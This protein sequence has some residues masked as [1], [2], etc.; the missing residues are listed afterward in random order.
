MSLVLLS[1]TIKNLNPVY[2]SIDTCIKRSLGTLIQSLLSPEDV[3]KR[4]AKL[5][6]GSGRSGFE[7]EFSSLLT[8]TSGQ[9]HGRCECLV[10]CSVMGVSCCPH[11]MVRHFY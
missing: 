10:H 1:V 2:L 11:Y 6:L 3:I 9:R 8:V 5:S 4:P 7:S